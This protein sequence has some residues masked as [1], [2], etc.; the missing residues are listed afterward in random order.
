LESADRKP[1]ERN[2]TANT[3]RI[4]MLNSAVEKLMKENLKLHERIDSII[5]PTKSTEYADQTT[6]HLARVR[7]LC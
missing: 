3:A 5:I 1:L 7:S 4:E 2:L 6:T